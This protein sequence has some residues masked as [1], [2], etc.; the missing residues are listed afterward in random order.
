MRAETSPYQNAAESLRDNGYR[1]MPVSPGTKTPGAFQGGVWRP[2]PGWQKYCDAPAP[3]FVHDQWERWPDAGVC[4][5]HGNAIGLDLDTDR[6]D[7]AEA[8]HGAVGGATVK[9]RG[10]KGWLGY[11]RPGPG[12]DG[13]AARVRWY[14]P[15]VTVPGTGGKPHCP[16][17]VE[18]L[19]HG[20]QSVLPPTIHPDTRRPYVWITP[21]TLHD[22]PV[23]DLPEFGGVQLAA[24]DR[25][26]A[27]IG[28]TRQAPRRAEAGGPVAS[29]P[30]GHDLEKPFGRSIND[31]ALEPSAIDQWWPAMGL[32]K[33]RQ[34]RAG[35]WEAVASWRGSGSGRNMHD[36][37]P[38]LK[39]TTTGI[40]D[41]GDDRPYTPIDLIMAWRD[42]SFD[43]AC[44]WLTPYLRPEEGAGGAV[45]DMQPMQTTAREV[46]A[47]VSA[48]VAGGAP[49][50]PMR[51]IW[52]PMPAF[53]GQRGRDLTRAAMRVTKDEFYRI[54][55]R[56]AGEFPI[57][58]YASNC[59]GLLG[60]LA[61]YLD[62]ASATS[63]EAGGLAVALPLLGAIMGRAYE[64]TTGLRTN[65]YSVALGAS[66]S[67]KTSLVSPAK[68][69]MRLAKA[70]HIMGA[71]RLKSGSAV[72]KMLDGSAPKICFLDEFGHM[73]QGMASPGAGVHYRDIITEFTALYS[74][75]NT[76]FCGSAYATQET[77]TIDSPH[78]CLF[79]MATPEQFWNAFGSGALED[80]SVARYLVFPIGASCPKDQD[81]SGEGDV[82]DAMQAVLAA[83]SGRVRGNLGVADV[84]QAAITP[85]AERARHGVIRTMDACAT[86]AAENGIKGA[87]SI[88]RRVAENAAKIALVSA[89]GRDPVAP[90]IT[91]ADFDIGH[92]L[93]RWSATVMI[94]NIAS[95][96]ADNQYERDVNAVERFISEAGEA[97]REWR[98][99]QRKF[100]SVR[101][102][103][104]KDI[105]EALEK[106]GSI[107]V[108]M[109]PNAYQGH[110]VKVLR[111]SRG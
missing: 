49:I 33:T 43:A 39:A 53:S 93:A 75:A 90:A 103:D 10:R 7:V 60:V 24:L 76:L 71:D 18:L 80:G 108:E 66:G 40:R 78:L 45:L 5:A 105:V 96:I 9:R 87:S 50:E 17:L 41:Y 95:H 42:C 72:L 74:A 82:A 99:V 92:A 14:D 68:E 37:N 62:C 77:R 110:P 98:H 29:S 12:L 65:I 64:T 51:D 55:P 20:T 47:E 86:Y 69:L 88:L 32:P 102:R 8:L 15:G 30:G 1:V 23:S 22:V 56:E 70:D 35:S 85:G 73:L 84:C 79:G 26:F 21:D 109:V 94:N 57:R 3:D 54:I 25:E 44:E 11:Y 106:E 34:R 91:E 48:E 111:V 61:D 28:L 38:N 97:G 46:V 67:G 104:L 36:R 52:Q 59:P 31:R 81:K 107:M 58:S 27:A 16:P 4:I 100:R 6:A 101:A 63:T 19:L 13:L 2:M 83:I 89:V